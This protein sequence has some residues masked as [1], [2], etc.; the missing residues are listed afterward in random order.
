MTRFKFA[1]SL[2]YYVASG[3]DVG[4]IDPPIPIPI[5]VPTPTPIDPTDYQNPLDPTTWIGIPDDISNDEAEA[6]LTCIIDAYGSRV[7]STDMQIDYA[8][9]FI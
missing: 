6:A 8:V 9:D 3:M 4:G 2:C 5:P 1:L 7:T